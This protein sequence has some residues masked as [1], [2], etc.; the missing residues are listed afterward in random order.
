MN[1]QANQAES[2]K[3]IKPMGLGA[4]VAEALTTEI[5]EGAYKGGEQLVEQ[6]LQTRFEVSRSPLREAFRELE[7][8]GLVTIVPRK[9]AFVRRISRK[10]VEE[11]FP[12]RAAL[13]GLAARL[14]YGS[15]SDTGLKQMEQELDGMKRAVDS[16]DTSLFYI[17]HIRFHEIF[18]EATG[19]D[20]LIETLK[21]LRMQSLWH[22][23]SF[24]YYQEGLKRSFR[25]H[26]KILRCF[27]DSKTDPEILGRLV[28]D[29][30]KVALEIF[31]A[32]LEK[33]ES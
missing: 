21:V 30:I 7:K 28:E 13:E 29:H 20:L 18:I 5:L 14:A 4:Q 12:V 9:G 17:H 25:V 8:R 31:L 11:H 6:E 26:Q 15:I 33:F 1:L 10:D 23:F 3:P 16:S 22:R 24:R 19:N 27:K 32:Y 2:V